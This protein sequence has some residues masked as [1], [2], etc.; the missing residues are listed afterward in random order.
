MAV[1]IDDDGNIDLGNQAEESLI[2]K[3]QTSSR[4]H[5]RLSRCVA[6]IELPMSRSFKIGAPVFIRAHRQK[7]F[8]SGYPAD[9]AA[10]ASRPLGP[11]W[12]RPRRRV[13]LGSRARQRKEL[14]VPRPCLR[15][16][17]ISGQYP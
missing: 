17:K 14:V 12:L 6:R 9:L 15:R 8:G 11:G 2:P 4:Q 7:R 5:L 1:R 3:R 10:A 13:T 16:T